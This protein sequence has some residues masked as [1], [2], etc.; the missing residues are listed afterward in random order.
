MINQ[1][2]L[3]GIQVLHRQGYSIRR[4][5]KE[6]GISRNTV[7]HY[8]REKVAISTYSQRDKKPS[9]LAPYKAYLLERIEAANPHWIPA[10][11]LL[12]EIQALGYDGGITMFKEHGM[13]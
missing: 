2:Q 4:I 13:Q 9:K 10:T 6:L 7:R 5:A 3:V 11:V 8:L 12:R 1:E